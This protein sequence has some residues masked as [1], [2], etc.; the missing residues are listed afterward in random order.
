MPI[1][2]YF[3]WPYHIFGLI[4]L[5]YLVISNFHLSVSRFHQEFI[6][7]DLKSL[8]ESGMTSPRAKIVPSAITAI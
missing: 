6:N 4:Y 7:F 3:P 8:T 2:Y 5:V 1:A